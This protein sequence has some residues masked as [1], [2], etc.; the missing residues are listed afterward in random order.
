MLSFFPF[1]T[2]VPYRFPQSNHKS[3]GYLFLGRH[4]EQTI[5]YRFMSTIFYFNGINSLIRMII[6]NKL[7]INVGKTFELILI[8]VGNDFI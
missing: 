5:F 2:P 6:K 3:V 1:Q 8:P 4:I 7:L